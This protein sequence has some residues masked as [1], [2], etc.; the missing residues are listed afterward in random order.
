MTICCVLLCA[1]KWHG[2]YVSSWTGVKRGLIGYIHT[3]VRTLLPCPGVNFLPLYSTGAKAVPAIAREG[4]GRSIFECGHTMKRN[5]IVRKA[6][7]RNKKIARAHGRY[8]CD[9]PCAETQLSAYQQCCRCSG[10][11]SRLPQPLSAPDANRHLPLLQLYA[12]SAVISAFSVGLL[13][14]K[15]SGCSHV[16]HSASITPWSKA[17]PPPVRP[18]SACGFTCF[19]ISTSSCRQRYRQRVK[20]GRYL[21]RWG[22]EPRSEAGLAI[23]GALESARQVRRVLQLSRGDR[24]GGSP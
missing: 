20:N 14:G 5:I 4:D 10:K 13:S 18:I 24:R 23:E 9:S 3:T 17:G 16:A 19:T 7:S 8:E 21:G 11:D 6:F 2:A 15:I 22:Y 12:F 1:L